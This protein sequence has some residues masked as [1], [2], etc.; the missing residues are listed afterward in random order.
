[1]T[2]PGLALPGNSAARSAQAT[3]TSGEEGVA[4][5]NYEPGTGPEEWGELHPDYASC[6]RG[7]SRSPIDIEAASGEGLTNIVFDYGTV[8]PLPLINNGNTILVPVPAGNG[9]E[10]DDLRYELLQFHFH[11]PSEHTVDGLAYAMELHLVHLASDGA[12]AVVSVLFADGAGHEALQ[13]V[14]EAFPALPGA[15]A[16]VND[17]IEL[18]DF[19][20]E[21]QT[22]YR[23][24]GSLTTPPCTEG[25]QWFIF[26]EPV[27]V[28][29]E[30]VDTFRTAVGENARPAQ[31]LNDRPVEEDTS[32]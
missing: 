30:Q 1:M 27:E 11:S 12:I 31:T 3:P 32:P 19:L 21:R 9:I 25:V 20:P 22:T 14:F 6:S 28:S 5:W 15:P 26:T 2:A 7:E 29:A 17:P 8:S 18:I 13:P 24:E 16:Q 4:P 10:V 23:Y